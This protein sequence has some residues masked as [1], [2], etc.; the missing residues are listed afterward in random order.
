MKNYIPILGIFLAKYPIKRYFGLFFV[1]HVSLLGIVTY[2]I[3]H[4]L[5]YNYC[6]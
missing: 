3:S 2:L 1:Y 5:I 6:L 4:F